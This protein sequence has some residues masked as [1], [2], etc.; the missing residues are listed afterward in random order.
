MQNQKIS[1][2]TTKSTP[3]KS[4]QTNNRDIKLYIHSVILYGVMNKKLRQVTTFNK[5][6]YLCTDKPFLVM[7]RILLV[8]MMI[9]VAGAVSAQ[10]KKRMRTFSQKYNAESIVKRYSDS[11]TALHHRYYDSV[12]V[13][14]KQ[15]LLLNPYYYRIFSRPT[16]YYDPVRQQ[17]D[18]D[19][20]GKTNRRTKFYGLGENIVDT[21]LQLD[22]TMNYILADFYVSHPQCISESEKQLEKDTG[23]RDNLNTKIKHDV[24]LADKIKPK[25]PEVVIEPVKVAYHKPNFWKFHHRYALQLQQN[26]FS[27]NWYQGGDNYNNFLVAANFK[28]SYDN[29]Q[30]VIF[31]NTLDVQLGMQTTKGDTVH[32]WHT[33]TDQIRLINKLDLRAIGKWYYS[34]QLQSV[35]QMFPKYSNNSNY[36]Y[37]DFFSPFQTT[38]SAGMDYRYKKKKWNLSIHFGLLAFEYKYVSR[39]KLEPRYLGR[40]K[41]YLESYGSNVS[42]SSNMQILNELNWNARI[43]YYTNYNKVQA[44]WE[45]TFNFTI[46]KYLSSRLYLYPRFDDTRRD[47][48]GK[49]RIQFKQYLS[50]GL[51]ISL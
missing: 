7:K 29:K 36:A 11:L 35:T 20:I 44:E 8:F 13:Y 26:Y 41:H 42:L 51:N 5:K 38:L 27:D 3:N 45:N 46:N 12:W 6:R 1:S 33:N 24:A 4:V 21:Q 25:E 49:R 40:K 31:D 15:D 39:S 18:N 9:M 30:Q 48:K 22:S 16:F 17:M 14:Q 10:H 34:L 23:L 50:L 47:K 19:W 2:R 43:Y 32:S 37:S 28:L